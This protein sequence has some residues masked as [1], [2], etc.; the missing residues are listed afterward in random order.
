MRVMN[1]PDLPAIPSSAPECDEL[2][3]QRMPAGQGPLPRLSLL[4]LAYMA[5][6]NEEKQR[7]SWMAANLSRDS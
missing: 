7:D 6:P 5:W 4:L 2:L 3:A 1:L